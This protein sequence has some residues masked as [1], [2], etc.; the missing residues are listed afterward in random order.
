MN[1]CHECCE[2]FEEEVCPFCDSDEPR[3]IARDECYSDD[4]CLGT[5]DKVLYT[6]EYIESINKEFFNGEL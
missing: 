2:K 6:N 3:S 5:G 4:D 1:Y